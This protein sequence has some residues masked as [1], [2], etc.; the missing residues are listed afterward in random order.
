MI[1]QKILMFKLFNEDTG[2]FIGTITMEQMRFLVEELEEESIDDMD[3]YLNEPT[4][5]M[6]E[7]DR[8]DPEL[9]ALLRKALDE[10][11]EVNII[12]ERA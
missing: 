5:D 7:I 12:W 4:I 8:A 1:F 10:H 11:G 3:Y 2:A 6:L 9:I